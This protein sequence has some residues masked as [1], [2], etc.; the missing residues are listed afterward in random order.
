MP[1]TAPVSSTSP[2]STLLTL[3]QCLG[4][5]KAGA[6]RSMDAS[7]GHLPAGPPVAGR[8]WQ[9]HATCQRRALRAVWTST[10]SV[11][12]LHF[13]PH[14]ARQCLIAQV[15]ICAQLGCQV[16]TDEQLGRQ[17]DTVSGRRGLRPVGRPRP[18]VGCTAQAGS[19]LWPGHGRSSAYCACG[20][21]SVST[22]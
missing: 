8:R 14:C 7:H 9:R 13:R 12:S 21:S 18:I 11:H 20:S 4:L 10:W 17:L 15:D 3:I 1:S 22:Q 19:A 6:P 2:S 5:C 16:V